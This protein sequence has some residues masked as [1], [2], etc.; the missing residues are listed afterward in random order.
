MFKSTHTGQLQFTVMEVFFNKALNPFN[1][2][3]GGKGSTDV[4]EHGSDD[5]REHVCAQ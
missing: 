3:S 2:V 4:G 1:A 5:E